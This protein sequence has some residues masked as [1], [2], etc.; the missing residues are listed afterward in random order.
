MIKIDSL[1]S[2]AYQQQSEFKKSPILIDAQNIVKSN[3]R[4]SSHRVWLLELF[5]AFEEKDR[6]SMIKKLQLA[7]ESFLRR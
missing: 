4:F 3:K 1:I 2:Y 6:E 5:A 7:K